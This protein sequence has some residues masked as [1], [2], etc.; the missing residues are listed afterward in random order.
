[1]G[2]PQLL[3]ELRLYPHRRRRTPKPLI[4]FTHYADLIYDSEIVS[5]YCI[6]VVLYIYGMRAW[7]MG[8]SSPFW[9]HEGSKLQ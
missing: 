9:F 2:F 6:G 1:M 8:Q 3:A 7:T 5:T 4:Y